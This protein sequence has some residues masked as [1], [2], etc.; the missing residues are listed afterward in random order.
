MDSKILLNILHK[1][2]SSSFSFKRDSKY[3]SLIDSAVES[4]G[5]YGENQG[6]F[7]LIDDKGYLLTKD[8]FEH[9]ISVTK[10]QELTF[11][12]QGNANYIFIN[13]TFF[14]R[15]IEESSGR[16]KSDV[17]K[18]NRLNSSLHDIGSP[19]PRRSL[20]RPNVRI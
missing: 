14:K 3:D 1:G 15:R 12:L 20:G 5:I 16:R 2:R 19:T 18:S 9:I 13:N 7:K 11:H 10:K 4:F 6:G 8:L 17:Q